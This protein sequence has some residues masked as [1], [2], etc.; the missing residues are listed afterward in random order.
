ILSNGEDL[1]VW[2]KCSSVAA[3]LQ[4]KNLVSFPNEFGMVYVFEPDIF[5]LLSTN[6]SGC[7]LN[8]K[9]RKFVAV[10]QSCESVHQALPRE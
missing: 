6:N 2:Q 9:N 10:N 1:R 8:L 3:E 5:D 7:R 4:N